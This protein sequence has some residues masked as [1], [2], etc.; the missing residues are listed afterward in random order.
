MLKD[1]P[2]EKRGQ[3][4]SF[5]YSQG[6]KIASPN[7]R[8]PVLKNHKTSRRFSGDAALDDQVRK[9]SLTP[10]TACCRAKIG[11]EAKTL[12]NRVGKRKRLRG[13]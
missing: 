13:T 10:I 6:I 2:E 11:D 8:T 9:K 4:A 12:A 3:G 5:D 1:Y 7:I